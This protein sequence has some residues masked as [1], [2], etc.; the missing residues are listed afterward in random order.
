MLQRCQCSLPGLVKQFCESPGQFRIQRYPAMQLAHRASGC[1]IR[2]VLLCQI[3]Q[4]NASDVFL[5]FIHC[6]FSFL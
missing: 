3:T 5:F 4:I 6:A 2:K 1:I